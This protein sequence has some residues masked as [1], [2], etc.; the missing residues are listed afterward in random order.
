MVLGRKLDGVQWNLRRDRAGGEGRAT[1]RH[2]LPEGLIAKMGYIIMIHECHS[3]LATITS[4]LFVASR[5]I[6][7][8]VDKE[9]FI[10]GHGPRKRGDPVYG[11]LPACVHVYRVTHQDGKNNLPMT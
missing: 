2:S 3:C 1:Y 9:S 5:D 6:L 10:S 11:C 8:P 4:Y 7:L